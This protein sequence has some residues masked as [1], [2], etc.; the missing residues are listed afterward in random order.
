[1]ATLQSRLPMIPLPRCPTGLSRL[2]AKNGKQHIEY[3]WSCTLRSLSAL[4]ALSWF[5]IGINVHPPIF[6]P[7]PSEQHPT[8]FRRAKVHR[9]QTAFPPSSCLG[10]W[11]W[12]VRTTGHWARRDLLYSVLL[13][14]FHPPSSLH[15]SR[16]SNTIVNKIQ[17]IAGHRVLKIVR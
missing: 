3:L 14:R 7:H 16:I 12:L 13:S 1:L 6:L 4:D 10:H 5:P 9:S 2:F 17:R 11:N 15:H 8:P